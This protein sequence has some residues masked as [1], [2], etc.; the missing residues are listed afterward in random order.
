MF[1]IGEDDLFVRSSDAAREHDGR[2]RSAVAS[3]DVP[4]FGELPEPLRGDGVVEGE[5]EVGGGNCF[6]P[7]DDDLPGLQAVGE[8]E[9][10]EVVAERRADT[11][12]CGL[13]GGEAGDD[14]DVERAPRLRAL[15]HALENGGCH[16][17]DAWIAG[18]DHAD[19][20]SC[21]G[22]GECVAGAVGFDLV[23][24]TIATLAGA[25]GNTVQVGMV[26]DEIGGLRKRLLR[27][28][29]DPVLGAGTEADHGDPAGAVR[30]VVALGLG[31]VGN[32]DEREVGNVRGIDFGEGQ[33]AFRGHGGAFDE[34][35]LVGDA[36]SIERGPHLR[37]VAS[38]LHDGERAGCA[39]P[40]GQGLFGECSGEDGQL[41]VAAD[42]RHREL[43]GRAH[44]GGH[45][46]DDLRGKAVREPVVEIH[47]RAVEEGVAFAENGDIAAGAE[48]RGQLFRHLVVELKEGGFVAAGMVGLFRRDGIDHGEFNLPMHELGGDDETGVALA[49]LCCRVGDDVRLAEDAQRFERH[50]LRVAGA[51]SDAEEAACLHVLTHSISLARALTAAAAMALPPRRPCTVMYGIASGLS[52]SACLD[53]AAPTKPTGMPR[54]STGRGAPRSSISSR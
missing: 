31:G 2:R 46:G 33:D 29:R 23:V 10:A 1:E 18:G 25:H 39:E 19:A 54:M 24:R 45:A 6:Q 50:E 17:E 13:H 47:V 28:W 9:D 48:M 12:G 11:G 5:C 7:L 53:S 20:A 51:E 16:G 40:R 43:G 22:E 37:E 52:T 36:C 21:F 14:A 26:A 44:D 35:G 8:R 4:C 27:F 32:E 15:F 49:V 38:E 34:E 42:E 30:G 41:G 3:D